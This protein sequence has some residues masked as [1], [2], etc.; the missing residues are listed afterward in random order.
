LGNVPKHLRCGE[1]FNDPFITRLLLHVGERI[2]KIDK[3]L[4]KLWARVGRPVF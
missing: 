4:V 2:L 3:H 1:I